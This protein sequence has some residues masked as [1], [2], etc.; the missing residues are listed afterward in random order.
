MMS[1]M[2]S[3]LATIRSDTLRTL[4]ALLPS[5]TKVA[6]VDFP[7]HQNAGDSLI[8][9]GTRKYLRELDVEVDYVAD[10][11]RY[12]PEHLAERL[13][14]G[15]ILI[16]GGGNFG[17]R[18]EPMQ[19]FRERV[20]ADFP[21]RQIIQ[22]PQSIEFGPGSALEQAQ[23]VL[24]AHRNLTILIRDHEGVKRTRELFPTATVTFCPD[25]AFGNGWM[26]SIA[27]G[28]VDVILLLRRDSE[29]VD[30]GYQLHPG[31]THRPAEWGLTG[32]QSLK[33][34]AL[35]IPGAIAKRSA[36]LSRLLYPTVAKAYERQAKLNV[37]TAVK[38]LKSGRLVVTDRL[39]A[40]VLASLLEMPVIAMDN[41]NGKVRAIYSD[42]LHTLPNVHFAETGQAAKE[43]V[44]RF[45]PG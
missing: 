1:G 27:D 38:V 4:S 33:W 2:K 24:G 36:T 22:L 26:R 8:W 39:H 44:D 31:L 29:A 42:Y 6:L 21:D 10:M 34:K 32:Y 12:A 20:V 9:T 40:M 28:P 30:H 23:R 15:P 16:Q 25:L 14:S 19:A 18:W 13:P 17:D 5:G 3:A 35:H 37:E 43:E 41:E 45:F 11:S 7:N